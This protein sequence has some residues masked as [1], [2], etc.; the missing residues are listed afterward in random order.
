MRKP[1]HKMLREVKG[2]K[3]ACVY[4]LP[5]Y[6]EDTGRQSSPLWSTSML[7]QCANW[8]MGF[9]YKYLIL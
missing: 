4:Q 6:Y 2:L 5:I 7:A 1:K 3:Y 9:C 8:E